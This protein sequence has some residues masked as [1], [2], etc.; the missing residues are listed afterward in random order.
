[1]RPLAL[2]ALLPAFVP[3]AAHAAE[4]C[5]PARV[6]VVLDRSSSMTTGQIAGQ[7]KWSIAVAGL[8][9]VLGAYDRDAE[10]GLITFP[11]PDQCSPGRVDVAPALQ[12][13]GAIIDALATPPPSAGNW[14]PMAQTLELAAEEP[15]L[16]AGPS[17]RHVILITDGWQYC[18]PYDPATR[19]DGTPAVQALAAQGV[20]TWIVGFGDEVDVE[21]LNQM[22]VAAHTDRP[23]CDA[24]GTD[25]AAPNNCYFQVDDATGL[26]AALTAIAGSISDETC[27]GVD[28]DCDG[29]TDEDLT[30]TCT[31]TCGSSGV[32]TCAAGG[33]A[34]CV[35]P[36]AS[37][38]TCDGV[39]NDCDGAI[40]EPGPELC[41]SG[42]VC[43][44]G[45][46]QPDGAGADD[47]GDNRGCGCDTNGPSP[48]A[49]APFAL[50]ALL[51]VRKRR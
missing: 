42:D 23:G 35:D 28:N 16:Q 34:D 1:M 7:T 18:D 39:D 9:Q 46:C 8:D 37:A 43:V 48:S 26:V 3:R 11:Q 21:A 50:L 36:Q 49:L 17:G 22:A 24:T 10:F 14:T 33:W 29:D 25:P 44:D 19:Y 20:T 51:L 30:R 5:E 2:L 41:D 31:T 27:D 12:N 15:V 13:R 47:T 4:Q 6:M 32:E 45:A 40:D 38:E